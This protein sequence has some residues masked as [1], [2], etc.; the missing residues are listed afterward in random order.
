MKKILVVILS[1]FC[2]SI[3]FSCEKTDVISEE[4]LEGKTWHASKTELLLNGKVSTAYMGVE[5][6]NGYSII[7]LTFS[8]ENVSVD[9][10]WQ[11]G[12]LN[13][14]APY[15]IADKTISFGL[16][17]G[18]TLPFEVV[19]STNKELLLSENAIIYDTDKSSQYMDRVH[20]GTFQGTDIYEI[21][22]RLGNYYCERRY[23]YIVNGVE[24]PCKLHS[25]YESQWGN[26]YES[27]DEALKSFSEED[28]NKLSEE[29]YAALKNILT[30]IYTRIIEPTE[31]RILKIGGSVG[32]SVDVSGK[33]KDYLLENY[34]KFDWKKIAIETHT[35][36][37]YEY[38]KANGDRFWEEY[39]YWHGT[40]DCNYQKTLYNGE[41]YV[42]LY[43]GSFISYGY[44]SHFVDYMLRLVCSSKLIL[45][46]DNRQD[47]L[48][49]FSY[50]YKGSSPFPY[51][52]FN[53]QYDFLFLDSYPDYD[54]LF[55]NVIN[56]EPFSWY[57]SRNHLFV[58]S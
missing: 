25:P 27:V 31:G 39:E 17:L 28:I 42:G 56:K 15:F 9:L 38:A 16:P 22:Y 43:V 19:K 58:A 1:V 50:I 3:L 49:C 5:L 6:E 29:D 37:E 47:L 34:D 11:G 46:L 33:F 23:Y 40:D 57:D 10:W 51:L 48:T 41:I 7:S 32:C 12:Q 18:G 8:S 45:N 21:V 30:R 14:I 13:H 35:E 26:T 52:H 53:Y 54:R 4:K 2:L 20:V 24:I 36:R 44:D 55:F